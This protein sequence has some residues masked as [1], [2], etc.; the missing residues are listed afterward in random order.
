CIADD[1]AI[2]SY[3]GSS[4]DCPQGGC[5]GFSVTLPA[6][7]ATDPQP[8]PRP[9]PVL[10]P[11][12]PD[13]NVTFTLASQ[14][15]AG[16]CYQP[17]TSAIIGTDRREKPVGTK[18]DDVIVGKGGRDRIFGRGGDDIIFAGPGN[19][20]VRAGRGRDTI[21]AG[22]GNDRVHGGRGPDTIDGGTGRDRLMGG[23]GQATRANGDPPR[24]SAHGPRGR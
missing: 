10:F 19:D 23:G 6:S 21:D 24:S 8:N 4:V 22:S 7:F 14:S 15:Y 2:C 13:W 3:A 20:V 16:S 1:S 18:G 11:Q 9:D 17:P 12:S 5:V